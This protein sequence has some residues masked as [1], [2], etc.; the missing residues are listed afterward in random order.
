MLMPLYNFSTGDHHSQERRVCASPVLANQRERLCQAECLQGP[1]RFDQEGVRIS[2][3]NPEAKI[4]IIIEINRN[5][6]HLDVSTKVKNKIFTS[7]WDHSE[8]Q[9]ET[10]GNPLVEAVEHV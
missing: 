5:P 4:L 7:F 9:E 8:P 2:V 6:A 1:A 10:E 3:Y